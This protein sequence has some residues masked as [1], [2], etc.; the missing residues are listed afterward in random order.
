LYRLLE[1]LRRQ[2][3]SPET[4]DELCAVARD[5]M[6]S[7]SDIYLGARATERTIKG[8][9]KSGDLRAYGIVHFATHGLL[10]SETESYA[11]SLAEPALLLTPPAVASDEEDGLLTASKVAQ[12]DLNAE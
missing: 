11:E 8:L 2:P 10:A 5:L 4:A 9:S 3:P 12:L 6:A 7:E 1:G